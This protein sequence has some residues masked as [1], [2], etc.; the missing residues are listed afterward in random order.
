MATRYDGGASLSYE[1]PTMR[2]AVTVLSALLIALP[3]TS[4]IPGPKKDGSTLLPS[5]WSIRPHGR[6]IPLESDLPI[7]AA[8]H[9]NGKVLAIQHAGYRE[10]R[11]VLFDAE[12]ERKLATIELPRTW[13]GMC[14]SPKGDRLYVSGGTA[15]VVHAFAIDVESYEAEKVASWTV[16]NGDV[17]DLPAGLC[18]GDEG[19]VYVTLQR[20][21]RVLGLSTD[22]TTEF[23]LQLE[24]GSFPF[25]CLVHGDRLFVSLWAKKNVSV[26]D[27]KTGALLARIPAG[28]HPSEMCLDEKGKRLFVSNGNENSVTVIDLERLKV[29]ETITS[30]LYASAPPGSTPNALALAPNG[31]IL[32]VANADNNNLA[33]VD[34]S[35]AGR[36]RGIGFIPVGAYP[37]S[38]RWHQGG[39]VFVLNGKGSYGSKRNPGGPSPIKGRPRNIAEYTGALFTGSLSAFTFPKPREL[40]QLSEIAYRCSPLH[41]GNQIRGLRERP[42]DSPIPSKLGQSSPIKHCVYIIKENRTYDQVLGDDPRGNGDPAL[43]L[44]PERVSP[45]HHA[46]AREFVLLDNFYV[47]AE[48]SADGHEWT[49]GAYASDFVERSWPVSY[50]GKGRELGYPS[51]GK[52]EIAFPK[53]RYLWDRAKQAGIT[54]RSYGEFVENGETPEDPCTTNMKTL[55]GNFDPLFRSYDLDYLDVDRAKR[56][57][58]EL[59]GFEKKGALPRLIVLRLPNDHTSGTRVGKPTPRAMMADNDL[60]LGMVVEGLSKSRFWKSTAIFVIEDDAQNGPDHVDAHRSIAYVISPYTKRSSVCST[61]Y[62]TCSMLRTMELIL[63]LAPMSQFDAAA[64]P[65]F[66]VFTGTPD[67]TPYRCREATW[68]L[69][70]KNEKTAW[71]AE[72]SEKLNLAVEDAADDILF[73]EIIWKSIKGPKSEMPMPRR[74][75]FV[76]VVER[77]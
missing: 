67:Y 71:G 40:Q 9:P 20:S 12:R 10:H 30:S 34:V 13:S 3:L 36:S 16:G 74:A 21:S 18:M 64:R 72:R 41:G 42:Q 56:F 14:W 17:L 31:Q 43:C 53:N 8:W 25:E 27:K 57:L 47:E 15:D 48:V 51:E 44:F 2:H 24:Q 4:Q 37:T 6:Q 69:D 49:M 65:M 46:L 70:E 61:M 73:N 75:A 1:R 7:R 33:V 5:G 23:A 58:T 28:E 60:A 52:F 38:V 62:S 11:V 45:N 39:K 32:L 26:F 77:D 59:D 54:F 29:S 68:P 35:E 55:E 22:G 50:G 76:R 63:G 19:R 66:E